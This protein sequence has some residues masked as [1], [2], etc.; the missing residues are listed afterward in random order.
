MLNRV[1]GFVRLPRRVILRTGLLVVT[2]ILVLIIMAL[3]IAIR[4]SSFPLNIGDVAAQDIQAPTAIEY[5]STVLLDQ[6]RQ[7][8]EA[9][10]Q[11]IYLPVDPS[12]TRRQI[13]R[14]H[15]ILD[16]ISAVRLDNYATQTQKIADL[17]NISDFHP[18]LA[19]YQ[20][21]LSLS[22]PRWQIVRQ[23]SLS[24]LE[25]VMRNTI[26]DNSLSDA[27]KN[28]LTLISYDIPQDQA[29]IIYDIVS[30]FVVPN[31]LYSDS[32][33]S[34]ARLEARNVVK[35]V[36]QNYIAGEIIVRRGQVITPVIYEALQAY[37]LVQTQGGSQSLIAVIAL[38]A[39]AAIFT[40]LYFSKRN[41]QPLSDA[42]SLVLVSI[43]FLL[44]LAGARIVIPNRT[45]VP[46]LFPLAA[47]GLTVG[48]LYNM[49]IGLILSLILS[50]LS[51]YNLP[52]SL[53]LTIFYILGSFFGI[54]VLG[55][56]RRIIS[57]FWAGLSIGAAGIAVILAYRLPES[58]TDWIGLA[59]LTG[60]SILGGLASASITLLFQFIFA[61]LLGVTTSMQ[62]L[63]LSRP[64]HPILQSL[65]RSAPGTYQH[66]LQVANLAEQAAEAINAE[67][68]L[69]RVGCLYHDIGKTNNSQFFVENQVPGKINSHDDMD[70]AISAAT[71]I[72]HVTDGVQLARKH[73]IPQRIQDF[74][75][76]HHGTTLTRYQYTRAVQ[77]AGSHP[78]FVNPE[79][80]RYPGP[81][82][83]S[84][85]TAILMLADGCEARARAEL[86]K[87]DEELR[88]IILKV[89][90]Y[91]QKEGQLDD[92]VL[93]LK[94]LHGVQDSF[95]LT[96]KNIYHPRIQYPELKPAELPIPSIPPE[97]GQEKP[98]EVNSIPTKVE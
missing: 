56:G 95:F 2:S 66:S 57:F 19:E 49:E 83:R 35:P 65:L 55:K 77:A 26:R 28:I 64:D 71:I 15:I 58:V 43:L 17:S 96:L 22:E 30:P 42:K 70:P 61:Q 18:G 29:S 33:T 60:A 23:E 79:L 78:E 34:Q 74:I 82:P 87:D 6:A 44:F 73:R 45:V 24:V 76:E 63:D 21:I 4:P 1:V 20:Q 85:E 92:T 47:F 11:P 27:Q 89:F 41:L 69:V 14:L 32:K 67:T 53:D 97:N 50:V 98:A 37:G 12:I 88:S 39:I 9:T 8:A 51:G 62:L 48:S 59:T 80:F 54:M 68:L 38:V 52:N 84:R 25:Q 40:G 81:R 10:V 36:L 5:P 13:E 91:I 90:E 16:Y 7:D 72:R 31:S 93:T 46:Y 3:P 94:D 75:R 86:P